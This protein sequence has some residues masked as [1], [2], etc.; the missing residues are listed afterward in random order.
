MTHDLT[1]RGF[2]AA[3][4]AMVAATALPRLAFGHSAQLSLTAATRVL[5]IDGKA[6]TVYGLINGAGGDRKAHV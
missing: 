3:S 5:E 4:A 6:A 1:R 2:I